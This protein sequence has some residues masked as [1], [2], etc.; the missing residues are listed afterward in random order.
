[1]TKKKNVTRL[2]HQIAGTKRARGANLLLAWDPGC[3]KTLSILDIFR[4]KREGRN[5]TVIFY[6]ETASQEDI[7]AIAKMDLS[8]IVQVSEPEKFHQVSLPTKLKMLVV[9]PIRCIENAWI[10]Q[11]RQYTN[12]TYSVIYD[13]SPKRRIEKLHSEADIHLV[14]SAQF[15]ILST[16]IREQNYD[17]LVI[18]ESSC[19]KSHDTDTTKCILSFAGIR[20]KKYQ[21][22][23]T[24]PHRY[25]LSGT[26]APNGREEYWAQITFVQPGLFHQNFF[27]FRDR[28]FY[29]IPMGPGMR[30]WVFKDYTADEFTTT[31][32]PAIDVVRKDEAL[33]LPG[34]IDQYY[35]I[36]LSSKE[37]ATYK[38]MKEELV[39]EFGDVMIL[40]PFQMT[41]IQK[42][43]QLA[44]GFIYDQEHNAHW[45]VDKTAK[46]DALLE[47]LDKLAGRS[48]VIWAD[49]RPLYEHLRLL[50]GEKCGIIDKKFGNP[51]DTLKDFVSRK[52]KIIVAN[53]ASCGHGIDGWQNVASEAIYYTD[54]WSLEKAQ[55][56]GG[57]LD[58]MGQKH[59]VT[60]YHIVARN[61]VDPLIC[62][63]VQSKKELSDMVLN[64]L[65][66]KE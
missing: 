8:S 56:S 36:D 52:L 7:D 54:N 33:D 38:Q 57:R 47:I 35:N 19:M 58:R 48:V 6:D 5:R 25:C 62:Q 49:F 61:T 65:R 1:M 55:Q 66:G 3:C 15:K 11:I 21:K 50:L 16:A 18:D 34:V 29:S 45:V 22:P 10:P 30:K 31:M 14:N 64:H 39:V 32:A 23:T 46:D 2:K 28:F 9:C 40:S 13:K 17:M 51:D 4:E 53:P 41:K 43:R 60:N 24:V 42:L 37:A 63:K 59:K 20:S 44:C 12:Y 27:A 26:P